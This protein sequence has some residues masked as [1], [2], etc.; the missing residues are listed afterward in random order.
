MIHVVEKYKNITYIFYETM[1]WTMLN[2]EG[3]NE[4][5][6]RKLI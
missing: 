5:L 2:R 4:K 6:N 3:D 1:I